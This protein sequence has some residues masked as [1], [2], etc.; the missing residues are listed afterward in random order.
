MKIRLAHLD[1]LRGF[2]ALAVV[3]DHTASGV[4]I[5]PSSGPV[6]KAIFQDGFVE[7]LNLGRFGVVLFFMISGFVIPYSLS[8]ERKAQRFVILRFFRLYPAYWL[9]LLANIAFFVLAGRELPGVAHFLA[10]LTMAP[11]LLGQGSNN[12]VYWTLFIELVFYG[13]CLCAWRLKLLT[14]PLAAA[15]ACGFCILATVGPIALNAAAGTHLKT[16]FLTHHLSF[17]FLGMVIRFAFVERSTMAKRLAALLVLCQAAALPVACGFLAPVSTAFTPPGGE[18]GN[19]SAYL[20]A[21][22]AFIAA[23]ASGKPHGP[24]LSW[25]G[26]VSYSVYLFHWP[27]IATLLLAFQP[28]SLIQGIGFLAVACFATYLVAWLV[29]RKVET[30]L[31]QFARNTTHAMRQPVAT[32]VAP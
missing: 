4:Q 16:Q 24:Q 5:S 28:T 18:F 29:Y 9:S 6:L 20:L 11:Q 25:M 26:D 1:A 32:E 19:L 3:V 30:P 12:G 22:A 17:L 31:N 8:T 21:M 14:S 23:A 15:A 27:V 2:A 7:T 13:L 10:D